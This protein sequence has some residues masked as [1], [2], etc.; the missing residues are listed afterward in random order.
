MN[1]L[2]LT[3]DKQTGKTTFLKNWVV[4]TQHIAGVLT[5]IISNKRFFYDIQSGSHYSMEVETKDAP[6]TSILTVGK[7]LFSINNFKKASLILMD[8]CNNE[9]NSFLIIDEIGP[10][11]LQQHKGFYDALL[12]VLEHLNATTQLIVVVRPNCVI[13]LQKVLTSYDKVGEVVSIN[14]LQ[15]M[16]NI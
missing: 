15:E 6:P 7:Y 11:E 12:F 10:L 5:P 16:L 3:G 8:A 13:D 14:V 9:R 4:N 2:I 1:I